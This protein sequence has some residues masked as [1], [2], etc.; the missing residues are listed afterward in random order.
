MAVGDSTNLQ[1]RLARYLPRSWFG[2]PGDAPLVGSALAGFAAAFVNIFGLI[3]FAIQQARI[4]T[5][6]GGWLDLT[7]YSFLGD[8]LPRFHLEADD[9]YRPRVRKEIFRDRNTRPAGVEILTELTGVAPFVFEGWYAPVNGG[10]GSGR[11]AYSRA[12]RWGSTNAPSQ[13]IFHV[14]QPQNY[15]IPRRG[16]WGSKTPAGAAVGG[17]GDG[18][19]S[20]TNATEIVGSGPSQ[21][22]ILQ[23]LNSVRTDGV[24]YFVTF[25]QP[26][27]A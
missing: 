10:R 17:Y 1:S 8:T 20:Y 22:E 6:T 11:L 3:T 14:P 25:I 9:A 15:G 2:Q 19:F 5:S 16:G 18:N 26:S 12:G 7:A 21:D 13:V 24:E 27:E 4:A 23:R